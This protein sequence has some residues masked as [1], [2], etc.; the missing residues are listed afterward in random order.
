MF[1]SLSDRLGATL[2]G[3][4]GQGRLSEE[5]INRAM[6]EI[7]LALLEADVNFGVVKDFVAGVRERAM[8]AEVMESLTPGQQVVKIVHE[9]LTELM[10]SA[11]SGLS[12]AGRPPTVILMAGLQGSGKT[13][14]C[15]KLARLLAKQKRSPAMV[16][17]DLQ[18]PAAVKQLQT[19]G[20]SLQVP[21]YERGTDAD[22]VETAVWGVEQARAQGRDVA[23]V[24]T[25]GRLHIDEQLMDELKRIKS[26]VRPHNVLLVLDAMTGQDAVN[27][28]GR[29]AEDVEFDGVVLTKLDGD[30]R[31]GAALAV[32]AVTGKPIKYVSVG[33][34]LDQ[35]EPFHPDR[36]ASRILGMGDV[37]SLIERA[38]E[39]IS[40]RD[41]REMEA[42]LRKAEFT[43][44]DFLGQLRQV[45]K[46][47]A[48]QGMAGLLGMLP[49]VGRQIKNM[50][51]DE[52]QID[53]V[54]AII[55]SMT[56]AERRNPRIIDGS[57]RRRIAAGSGSSVQHVNQLLGQFKQVQK[58]MKQI[59]R[60][61]MPQLPGIGM[62]SPR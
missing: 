23:I 60:G 27:V 38:Q 33:E 62:R 1:E 49:G 51:V 31:G 20:A 42:K 48:G 7:R 39:Q 45:R 53:R 40:E 12:F 54:E 3:L 15:G 36:L 30:A 25:A 44:D 26:A 56:P 11:G 46:M 52:R 28:A 13:T 5:D 37:M 8:G 9:E 14:A 57:R 59:G 61:K 34:K 41:A 35:L 55:L 21:V 24:D 10:G 47:T 50:K 17:C 18:R 6:R 22:P 32:R 29:F 16:A 19:L 4:R 43:L 2:D 58:M